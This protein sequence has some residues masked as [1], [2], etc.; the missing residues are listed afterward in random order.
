M[1]DGT[2]DEKSGSHA[3]AVTI[4]PQMSKSLTTAMLANEGKETVMLPVPEATSDTGP[5]GVGPGTV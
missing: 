3:E 4:I 5:C 2:G 1:R